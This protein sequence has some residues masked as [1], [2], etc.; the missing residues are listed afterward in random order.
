M[1]IVPSQ[2]WKEALIKEGKDWIYVDPQIK[3]AHRR[4]WDQ[5][6]G[7]MNIQHKSSPLC[8]K[9]IAVIFTLMQFFNEPW[10]G[11]AND[12]FSELISRTS[13]L[14]ILYWNNQL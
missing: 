3:S 12:Y 10:I 1:I 11:M 7:I 14:S 6:S 5:A 4:Y 8:L 13:Q 2:G 9:I